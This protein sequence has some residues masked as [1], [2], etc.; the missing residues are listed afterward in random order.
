MNSPLVGT[1]AP[2]RAAIVSD[3][4]FIPA[5]A[6]RP[7]RPKLRRKSPRYG[8]PRSR[9]HDPCATAGIVDNDSDPP[10]GPSN[11][12]STT[13]TRGR[14][15]MLV[16][17]A[18]IG[19]SRV[20]KQARSAAA[21]GWEVYLL[22]RAKKRKSRWRIGDAQ[23]RLLEYDNDLGRRPRENRPGYLRH[24]LAYRL[25]RLAEFRRTEAQ[26][27]VADA[28]A[29]LAQASVEG[30]TTS[31]ALRRADLKWQKARRRWALRRAEAT[32][33]V[34]MNRRTLESPIDRFSTSVT[35]RLLGVRAWRKFDPHL[36]EFETT[37][38]PVIDRLKPDIIHANDFRMLG[39]GARAMW[40]ARAAGRPVK[41][42]WDAHEFLPGLKPWSAHPHWHTAQILH[43]REYAPAA[44]AVVTVTEPLAELLV[45]EHGLKVSPTVVLNAPL[46]ATDATL[47]S[48]ADIR[49]SCGLGPDVPLLV[50][51]GAAAPQRG[52]TTMIEALPLLPG[53]H[54]ALVV[55][56]PP[57]N[58]VQEVI[59]LAHRL[60]VG[61]RLHVL[62]YVPVEEI[63]PFL[64]SATVGIIPAH[65][66]LN[67]EISLGTKFFEYSHARLPIVTSNLKAMA[68]MVT[69]TGQG[70][71]FKAEDTAD[72]VR[73]VNK[74]LAAP[75][76]YR[77]AYQDEA[78]LASWTWE[79]Q[80]EILD[81]VY[82]ALMT[83]IRL[84]R[85]TNS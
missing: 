76:A 82:E 57:N 39:V 71:V 3:N 32:E 61:D 84:E 36:L 14:I 60:G 24:P 38:G 62:P 28:H 81:G 64:S 63:V 42:V 55:N 72:Y 6:T 17:N 56:L 70:E 11:P 49:T 25:P 16:D 34:A 30:T 2:S 77:K 22:G 35:K 53:V 20:Q 69:E 73:A 65:K 68:D 58:Y 66:W 50:Y 5:T 41:L 78:L 80:A 59:E 15:I 51:S 21:A 19:D 10:E 43:E 40:R 8:Y 75:E 83:E 46:T 26:A 67:H 52:L 33:Q 29:R 12:M 79:R 9:V 85:D 44:D 74:V 4:R 1:N 37:F 31:R 7:D 18:V 48:S 23:V 47:T 27:R 45:A 54:A 13:Q